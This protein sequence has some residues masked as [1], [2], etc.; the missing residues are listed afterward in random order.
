MSSTPVRRKN[1]SPDVEFGR[2]QYPTTEFLPIETSPLKTVKL[3]KKKEEL[4][5]EKKEEKP[6]PT[7]WESW[8]FAIVISIIGA[9]FMTGYILLLIISIK[10]TK[11]AEIAA[12]SGVSGLYLPFGW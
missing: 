6:I 2:N 1:L 11:S 3:I 9:V 8:G 12:I 10:Q 5:E 4:K 7:F